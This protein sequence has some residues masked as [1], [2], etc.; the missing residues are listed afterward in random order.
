MKTPSELRRELAR[1]DTRYGAAYAKAD[2][3]L[4]NRP[5]TLAWLYAKDLFNIGVLSFS[6]ALLGV[7]ALWFW[8]AVSKLSSTQQAL[9]LPLDDAAVWGGMTSMFWTFF[10]VTTGAL[11]LMGRV[12]RARVLRTHSDAQLFFVQEDATESVFDYNTTASKDSLP[13]QPQA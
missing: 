2:A 13:T 7:P 10:I 11:L 9:S 6:T 12:G 4:R 3:Q 5:F 8:G 1:L